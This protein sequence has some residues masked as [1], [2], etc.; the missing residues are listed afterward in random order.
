MM[1]PDE[2]RGNMSINVK[3]KRTR[4]IKSD[5]LWRLVVLRGLGFSQKDIAQRLNVGQETISYHLKR[6]KRK[7]VKEG[8]DEY[9]LYID[10]VLGSNRGTQT[11]LMGITGRLRDT[12]ERSMLKPRR[13]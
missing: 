5:E 9:D 4:K 8:K 13:R 3:K 6:L 10:I 11:L 12:Y 7:I 2:E 1:Y